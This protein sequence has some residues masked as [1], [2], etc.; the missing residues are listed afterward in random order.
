[1]L[2]LSA[3]KAAEPQERAESAAE[4]RFQRIY[5]PAD[6][7]TDW[8]TGEGRYLPMEKDEFDRLLSLAQSSVANGQGVFSAQIA[9]AEYRASLTDEQLLNG[10]ASIEYY[11]IEP[12]FDNA[13]DG[14]LQYG[15]PSGCLA[16]G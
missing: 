6:R 11:A 7:M 8:P 5:A 13:A 2:V 3:L 4:L 14:A 16:S 12:N 15:D 10:Q 9:A 1:M